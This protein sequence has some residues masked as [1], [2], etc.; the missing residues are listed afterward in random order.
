MFHI[1][2]VNIWKEHHLPVNFRMNYGEWT[3]DRRNE[4]NKWDAISRCT[5]QVN[6]LSKT[7]LI[8]CQ[9]FCT[10]H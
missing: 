2:F 6:N 1:S 3:P 10:S 7:H 8:M 9:K 4:Y 5:T